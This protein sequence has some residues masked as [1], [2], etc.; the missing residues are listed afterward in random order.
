MRAQSDFDGTALHWAACNGHVDVAKVLIE[1]KIHINA[2][3]KDGKTALHF[4][5]CF[6]KVDVAKILIEKGADVDE[7]VR[8]ADESAK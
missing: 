3:D 2:N 8:R 5:A 4:A 6:G 7:L 1:N